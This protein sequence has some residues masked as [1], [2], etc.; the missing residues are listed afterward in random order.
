V[1]LAA[2][3]D[4]LDVLLAGSR[5]LSYA[6]GYPH[7]T[8]Y[9]PLD[10]PRDLRDV[11]ADEPRDA[12]ALYLHVPFCEQRCGF[13][14]LFTAAGVDDALATRYL[15]TLERQARIVRDA[16]GPM[17]IAATA[18][19]GGTPT[20][21]SARDLARL[22]AL[23]HAMGGD[24]RP[25]A[26]ETSPQ[27][28][29]PDRLAVLADAGV[30]RLSIGVQS[31]D[32]HESKRLQRHQ[33]ARA[34]D[35]ALQAIRDTSIP[36]LNID[37]MYGIEGQD[38]GSWLR[39][40]DRALVWTPEELY[41]YPLYVRPLTGLDGREPSDTRPVLYALGRDR[42]VAAG[43]RQL[44]MR[45]F[46]RADATVAAGLAAGDIDYSCERDG[47]IGLGAGARSYTRA[48]HF[49]PAYAVARASV[50]TLIT[51]WIDQ[52]DTSLAHAKHG[53]ALDRDEQSRRWVLK[54][55]LHADGVA[56]ADYRGR[57]AS[58]LL[59]DRP[60]LSAL[61]DRGIAERTDSAIRL[62]PEGMALSDVLSVWLESPAVR[63]LREGYTWQ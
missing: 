15:D 22:L 48:L 40:I 46:R 12:L 14:N 62:T 39:A 28:A 24:D 51:E 27:T 45:H 11:W 8:A 6:Y 5:Y 31:F 41:L 29:T 37:L 3:T 13:C 34:V 20:W 32:E 54:S 35:A 2:A 42:L 10:P 26:V 49:A 57:F 63:A 19:G 23:V 21:Y 43:Y 56:L 52:D 44:S 4:A 50:R 16:V 53:F 58:A 61:L 1:T 33:P 60:E 30:T 38:A 25:L 7:K 59:D 17:A 9:R 36:S 47:M 18:I 55:L